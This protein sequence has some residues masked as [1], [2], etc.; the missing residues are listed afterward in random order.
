MKTLRFIFKERGVGRE[1]LSL[2][3][4]WA[5][6]RDEQRFQAEKKEPVGVIEPV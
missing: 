2:S 6:G 4:Y 3:A 1:Q 5:L